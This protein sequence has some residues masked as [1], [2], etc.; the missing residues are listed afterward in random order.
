MEDDDYIEPDVD[1]LLEQEMQEQQENDNYFFDQNTYEVDTVS[2]VQGQPLPFE[3]DDVT[4]NGG[5]SSTSTNHN[6]HDNGAVINDSSTAEN[7]GQVE[8]SAE[9][10][11]ELDTRDAAYDT[12]FA[13]PAVAASASLLTN[14]STSTTFLSSVPILPPTLSI[15]AQTNR[16]AMNLSASYS[17]YLKGNGQIYRS[18]STR[19]NSSSGGSNNNNSFFGWGRKNRMLSLT[20]ETTP[21]YLQNRPGASNYGDLPITIDGNMYFLPYTLS[22][23]HSATFVSSKSTNNDS[24]ATVTVSSHSSKPTNLSNETSNEFRNLLETVHMNIASKRIDAVARARAILQDDSLTLPLPISSIGKNN[25]DSTSKPPTMDTTTD[26][27]DNEQIDDVS[28]DPQTRQQIQDNANLW[29]SKYAPRLFVDLLSPDAI[30][31]EV[32]KWIKQWDSIVFGNKNSSTNGENENDSSSVTMVPF[33]GSKGTR[34]SPGAKG[35]PV[36]SGGGPRTTYNYPSST[37][38]FYLKSK[39]LLICGPP[40]TGKTTLAHIAAHQ[41]GYR[42]AEVN[43]SDDRTGKSIRDLIN[44]AQTMRSVFGDKR[45]VC[46]VLDE[47]DGMEGGPT[48]GVAELVKMIKATNKAAAMAARAKYNN[49]STGDD[50]ANESSMKGND[51]DDN[52]DFGENST[53][54]VNTADNGKENSNTKRLSG[55]KRNRNTGNTDN[56]ND[57]NNEGSSNKSD[58]ALVLTRPLICICNDVY[59]SVLRELRPL[60]QIVELGPPSP[61]RL[62]ERIQLICRNE[63]LSITPDAASTLVRLTDADI[64]SCLNTLQFIKAQQSLHH[65]NKD[66]NTNEIVST[67]TRIRITSETIE[68]AAVS[69]KDE[70]KAL[71]D[72][73]SSVYSAQLARSGASSPSLRYLDLGN[74]PQSPMNIIWQQTTAYASDSRLLLSG[75]E[76]NLLRVNTS[77]PTLSHTVQALDWLCFGEEIGHKVAS[78]QMYTLS[79]YLP[80]ATAGIHLHRASDIRVRMQWPRTDA[81]MRSKHEHHRNIVEAFMHGRATAPGNILGAGSL[82][83][84]STILDLLSPLLTI[85]NPPLRAIGNLSLMNAV[86]QKDVANLVHVS[87]LLNVIR[88]LLTGK[89]YIVKVY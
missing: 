5:S 35:G 47:I 38:K 73:W 74:T 4:M 65:T 26:Q 62:R 78:T 6:N 32:L 75:L 37:N 40:G 27:Q 77:D 63:G 29:V 20:N 68:R 2:R 53:N 50:V 59:A 48:G 41:A 19:T 7:N 61:D 64:R 67:V 39:V 12:I 33:K 55:K 43:A 84:R 11:P 56:D 70:T 72:V 34:P 15:D 66:K 42:T 88:L 46:V 30:N 22:P 60:V 52:D 16:M 3:D 69:S 10:Y 14:R 36:K 28:P 51:D 89:R 81:L 82:D 58:T 25:D 86:E 17:A 18:N 83:H 45:P 23:I 85:T 9:V 54:A 57:D 80:A 71:L 13:A 49:N 44:S 76:E 1:Y 21:Q 87:I 24:T 31:R 8:S 79:K